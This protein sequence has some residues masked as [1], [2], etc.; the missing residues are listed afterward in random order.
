MTAVPS[1][2]SIV[3]NGSWWPSRPYRRYAVD[4]GPS[5][6]NHHKPHNW[7]LGGRAG[8]KSAPT[9]CRCLAVP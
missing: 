5:L 9:A 6:D 7:P 4:K 3:V 1:S 8:E 2:A